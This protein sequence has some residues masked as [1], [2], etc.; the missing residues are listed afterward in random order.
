[1]KSLFLGI[2]SFL[3]LNS[4]NETANSNLIII[5]NHNN[6]NDLMAR[7]QKKTCYKF[8]DKSH[9]CKALL[10]KV[11]NGKIESFFQGLWSMDFGYGGQYALIKEGNIHLLSSDLATIF[12]VKPYDRTDALIIE[13]SQMSQGSKFDIYLSLM[14]ERDGFKEI[15]C[16]TTEDGNTMQGQVTIGDVTFT[17]IL[18]EAHQA[19]K[20]RIKIP[21]NA[22]K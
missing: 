21:L 15:D 10:M 16:E 17:K 3:F 11:N 14:K 1:M 12:S 7:Y 2:I 13:N 18:V 20:V 6:C 22:K 19:A 5:A 9:F 8:E 4:C